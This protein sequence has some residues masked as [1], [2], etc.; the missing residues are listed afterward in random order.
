MHA[1]VDIFEDFLFDGDELGVGKAGFGIIKDGH[2]QSFYHCLHC[3]VMGEAGL[4]L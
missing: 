4:A 3:K 1:L 2:F